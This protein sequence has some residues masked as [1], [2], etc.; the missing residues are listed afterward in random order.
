L[1]ACPR[2]GFWA[3]FIRLSSTRAKCE[4]L[5]LLNWDQ[6]ANGDNPDRKHRPSK[7][8]GVERGADNL[9]LEKTLVTKSEEAVAGYFSWQKLQRKARARVGLSSKL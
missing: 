1:N 5:T 8:A 2:H 9:T 6:S 7:I 3:T 4:I